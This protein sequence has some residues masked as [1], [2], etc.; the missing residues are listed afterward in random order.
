MNQKLLHKH[1]DSLLIVMGLAFLLIQFLCFYGGYLGYDDLEYVKL[2]KDFS[3]G[4]FVIEEFWHY[5]FLECCNNNHTHTI[6]SLFYIKAIKNLFFPIQT[7]SSFIYYFF[8]HP[9]ALFGKANA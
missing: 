4:K 2:A 3:R 8:A 5:R 1:Q 9:F 7:H 6:H